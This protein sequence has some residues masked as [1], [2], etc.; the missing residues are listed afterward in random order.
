MTIRWGILGCGNVTEKKSGPALY[1]VP[2]SSLVAVMRR[3]RAKA[4]D[5][6]RRHGAKRAYDRAEDL[7]ADSEVD[8]IYI[9]TPPNL[10]CEQAVAAARAG[11]RVLV[12]K[13]MALNADEC[14][15]MIAA[16]REAGVPLHVAYYRHFY[17]KFVHARRLM[18]DG[19]I[20]RAVGGRLLMCAHNPGGGWRID[21]QTGGGGH[22]VDVGSH[23]LEMLL[24]LLGGGE[25]R[26]VA[27][28]ADN[29]LGTHAAENDVALCLQ[30]DNGAV[31]SASFH[32]NTLPGRDLLEIYGEA[33]TITFDPFDGESF[34]VRTPAG[35]QTHTFPNPNPAHGPFIAA[36]VEVYKGANIPHVTG[37]V[38]AQVTQVMDAALATYRGR[39]EALK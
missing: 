8:A 5:Y 35:E 11:K 6:A 27:G 36:L 39:S 38:G 10:H 32:Y 19:A 34:T 22:F 28:F 17:P 2:G 20:G 1:G 25:V 9:A 23:R 13:P 18:D 33:G 29:L 14:E 21:P 3:D 26:S 7:L 12:E 30:M 16:C 31:A 37:E 4:E 15:T 24:H